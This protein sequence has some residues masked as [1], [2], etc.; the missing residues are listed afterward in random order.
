MPCLHLCPPLLSPEETGVRVHTP[1]AQWGALRRQVPAGW[2]AA[3]SLGDIEECGAEEVGAAV[4]DHR[5]RSSAIGSDEEVRGVECRERVPLPF[6]YGLAEL[7]H[8]NRPR[9][10]VGGEPVIVQS[11]YNQANSA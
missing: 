2:R 10:C 6:E 4:A 3:G 1:V 11:P 9:V 8:Q 5:L 7:I